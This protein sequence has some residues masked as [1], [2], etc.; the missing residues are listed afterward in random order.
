MVQAPKATV[1]KGVASTS[2][3]TQKTASGTTYG[4]QG[5]PMDISAAAATAKCYQCRKIGHFKRD[6]PNTPKT[7]EEALHQFNTY[8]DHHPMTE[9]MVT[10]DEVKEDTEK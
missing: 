9:A 7:R 3:L 6:C 5:V 8:W 4:G 1:P 2:V 10:I